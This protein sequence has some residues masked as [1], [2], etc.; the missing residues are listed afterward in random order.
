MSESSGLGVVGI[1]VHCFFCV[2]VY[3][4]YLCALSQQSVAQSYNRVC[5]V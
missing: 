1:H 2:C 4:L 3:V 5:D